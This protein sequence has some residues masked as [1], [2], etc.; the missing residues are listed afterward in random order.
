MP[1]LLQVVGVPI[2]NLADMPP[3]AL[4]A[5][6]SADA[7]VC[8]DTRRTGQLLQL[9]ALGKKPL[10]SNHQNNEYRQVET[11]LARLQV[12]AQLVLVSD[13]GMPA[14]SDPGA[15]LVAAARAAGV[16]VDVIPGPCAAV[17]AV[18]G[19]GFAGGFVLAGFPPRK[20]RVRQEWLARLG[21]SPETVV[22]Y[23][24]PFRVA[25]LAADMLAAWGNRPAWLA[26]ELT[27]MHE[28]WLGP[29]LQ[30]LVATLQKRSGVKGEC[31]LVVQG[32]LPAP[33]A[34]KPHR[35]AAK[36]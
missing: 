36:W 15:L 1:G 29:N 23:E 3:R 19:S 7:I 28:E 33:K 35:T 16:R 6:Q 9:M 5:L 21:A 11:L 17:L 24:S 26:R 4:Q 27:K 10:I 25:D 14:I 18:A 30:E 34:E 8:E 31:V 20:G 32:V 12:G 13:S 22:A 2:G